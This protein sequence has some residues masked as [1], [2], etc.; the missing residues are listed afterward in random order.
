MSVG[1][2]LSL[3]EARKKKLLGRFA[4][5]HPSVGNER[6]FDRMLCQMASQARQCS[7]RRGMRRER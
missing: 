7:E 6:P 1:R 5:A 3:E 4:K 2:Y